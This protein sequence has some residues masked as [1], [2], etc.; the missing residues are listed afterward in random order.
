MT[1]AAMADRNVLPKRIFIS[2]VAG[3]L[4]GPRLVWF[5]ECA[6]RVKPGQCLKAGQRPIYLPTESAEPA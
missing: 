4:I 2:L 6:V 5:S 3:T 1:P